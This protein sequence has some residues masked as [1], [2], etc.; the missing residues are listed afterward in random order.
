MGLPT[1][2]HRY[3][4]YRPGFEPPR[5]SLVKWVAPRRQFRIMPSRIPKLGYVGA[6][7]TAY[8]LYDLY[9]GQPVSD[10]PFVPAR[11]VVDPPTPLYRREGKIERFELDLEPLPD[12]Y[13][14]IEPKVINVPAQWVEPVTQET[15]ERG[16]E[17]RVS[18]GTKMAGNTLYVSKRGTTLDGRKKRRHDGK[19]ADH[20]SYVGGLRFFNRT[21]GR[22]SELHDFYEAIAW[23]TYSDGRPVAA[24]GVTGEVTVDMAGVTAS[25]LMNEIV[26]RV[27]GRQARY[28][29]KIV[30]QSGYQGW[31][32]PGTTAQHIGRV[33]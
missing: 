27:V 28:Q 31:Q 10:E 20:A 21:F 17:Y 2:E 24:G 14:L 30:R 3:G 23:N 12:L 32:L 18:V 29:R 9:R 8:Q 7:L 22:L 11:Q 15:I 4:S 6:A 26:D 16:P 1:R 5:R 19:S 25:L 13:E 33:F